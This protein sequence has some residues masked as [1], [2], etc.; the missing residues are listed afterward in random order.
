MPPQAIVPVQ[1]G[2]Y[3]SPI[4]TYYLVASPY[5]LVYLGTDATAPRKL[6]SRH[7]ERFHIVPGDGLLVPALSQLEAYFSGALRRFTIPVDLFGTSFQKAVWSVVAL[8]PYGETRSYREVGQLLG[9]PMAARAIGRANARNPVS[10]I[11]P[12]HRVIGSDARLVGYGGGLDRKR[13]LLDLE[14]HAGLT[15]SPSHTT[16]SQ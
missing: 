8:I 1:L 14:A 15:P 16:H 7:G 6:G 10:I 5:G 2:A 4:G 12:C 13:A 9:Y 3:A 11:I